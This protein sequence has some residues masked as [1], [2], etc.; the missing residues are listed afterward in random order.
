[1]RF[2]YYSPLISS[3]REHLKP[4]LYFRGP[5]K[6]DLNRTGLYG[7]HALAFVI[8]T[9]EADSRVCCKYN[10]ENVYHHLGFGLISRLSAWNE[11]QG[12]FQTIG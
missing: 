9:Y 2:I 1:M 8:K 10:I 5:S 12:M 3:E 4:G 11:N 6:K 7:L